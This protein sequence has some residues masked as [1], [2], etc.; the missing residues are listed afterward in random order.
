MN[1]KNFTVEAKEKKT[2]IME[3]TPVY[4]NWFVLAYPVAA[5]FSLPIYLWIK[6]HVMYDNSISS[7]QIQSLSSCPCG[8]QACKYG[9][10]LIEGVNNCLSLCYLSTEMMNEIKTPR[11]EK[12]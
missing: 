6:I 10:V 3:S 8:E 1:Y 7:G 4:C 5:I 11:I 12:Y 9:S 2:K